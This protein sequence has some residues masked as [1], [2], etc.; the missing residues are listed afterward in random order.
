[1]ARN[2]LEISLDVTGTL[3]LFYMILKSSGPVYSGIIE[4]MMLIDR[5]AGF[6]TLIGFIKRN[7]N[8]QLALSE[9]LKMSAVY[10]CLMRLYFDVF[11]GSES[12]ILVLLAKI[13]V[14]A[15]PFLITPFITLAVGKQKY[16]NYASTS[17]TS[18]NHHMFM[19]KH[20]LAG[21]GLNTI[22]KGLSFSLMSG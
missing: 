18:L 4:T 2:N 3:I 11:L 5:M 17:V 10:F 8:G 22:M 20:G 12:N 6:N 15:I 14:V 9:Y 7:N 13:K 1:M 16:L 19:D 21:L